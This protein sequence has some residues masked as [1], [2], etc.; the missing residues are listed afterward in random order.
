MTGKE[1]AL[2]FRFAEH[3]LTI[4]HADRAAAL[5]EVGRRLAAH[6]GFALATLNLDHLVKLRRDPAFRTA[7]AR[8]DIVVADGNPVVWLSRLAGR[9]VDLVPGADLVVPLAQLAAGCGARVALVGSTVETLEAATADLQARVPGLDVAC[10][11]APPFGFDPDSEAAGALL[12]RLRE[13]S[14]GLAFLALG[15][16]KQER[17]AARGLDLAPQTGFASIGAGL[18][19]LAGT[20][21]RAPALVRALSLEWLW[22]SLMQPRRMIPRY[23]ACAAI[24]PGEAARALR[25]RMG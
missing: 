2:E 6:R 10:T 20:Q 9:P 8:Q 22:R 23:A 13:D 18:D 15:A 17:L 19:F 25:Q 1:A 16:P 7:Y 11:I 14:I 5:A 24:L 4:T 12:S 21:H 3:R